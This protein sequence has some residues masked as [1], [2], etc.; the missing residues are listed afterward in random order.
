MCFGNFCPGF[1]LLGTVRTSTSLSVP[2]SQESGSSWGGAAWCLYLFFRHH[3]SSS[4]RLRMR[5]LRINDAIYPIYRSRY[6]C[7]A[8][9]LGICT[10][11]LPRPFLGVKLSEKRDAS[12]EPGCPGQTTT[13][14][15]SF[16]LAPR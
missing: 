14:E 5:F 7:Q 16:R 12:E 3:A 15:D 13:N 6:F 10:I 11:D 9:W 8:R 4:A 2:S 1:P